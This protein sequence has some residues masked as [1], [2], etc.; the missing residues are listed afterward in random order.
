MAKAMKKF[1][2]SN[3][4]EIVV[5]KSETFKHIGGHLNGYVCEKSRGCCGNCGR[6]LKYGEVNHLIIDTYTCTS[7][8]FAHFY[9]PGCNENFVN[10]V[11]DS[12]SSFGSKPE[13]SLI[14]WLKN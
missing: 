3:C 10:C 1:R 5:D 6:Y 14:K 12:K 7:N 11:C 13:N 4:K 2:C 9:C 8:N